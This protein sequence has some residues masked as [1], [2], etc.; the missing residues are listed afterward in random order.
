[1][2]IYKSKDAHNEVSNVLVELFIVIFVSLIWHL[3]LT[4]FHSCMP[5]QPDRIEKIYLMLLTVG[6]RCTKDS[7]C[8]VSVFL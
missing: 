4:A 7:F 2:I 8:L 5:I 3:N 1:M 6:F